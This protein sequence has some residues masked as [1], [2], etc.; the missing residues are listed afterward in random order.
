MQAIAR[1]EPVLIVWQRVSSNLH[2]PF[3]SVDQEPPRARFGT[4][5]GEGQSENVR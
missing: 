4:A 3:Q 5:E 2:R 1:I